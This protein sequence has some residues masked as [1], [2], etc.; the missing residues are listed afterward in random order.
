M[1]KLRE[2]ILHDPHEPTSTS[3]QL[4]YP[5][6]SLSPEV[7]N[8]S[9][10]DGLGGGL[11]HDKSPN[12]ISQKLVLLQYHECHSVSTEEIRF[13]RSRTHTL[14][15]M[16][17]DLSRAVC[18]VSNSWVS[19][20]KADFQPLV[21]SSL[22][23]VDMPLP[24]RCTIAL[25]VSPLQ[26]LGLRPR[27]HAIEQHFF[28]R[29]HMVRQSGRH[30]WRARPPQLGRATTSGGF[31]KPQR[32]TQTGVR[33][34]EIV[35][36]VVHCQLLAQAVLTC[37]QGVDPTPYRCYSLANIQVQPLDKRRVN[38]PA[39]HRQD[40]LNPLHSAKHHPILDPHDASASVGLDHLGIKHL[41]QGHPAWFGQRAFVS[42]ACR[43][44][45]L[46]K[47]GQEGCAVVLETI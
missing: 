32:L 43:L 25:L 40:L 42:T 41:R 26:R 15:I 20:L 47:M 2:G 28:E 11:A 44:P 18:V 34:A 35:V 31:G 6:S 21:E 12:R 23:L 4:P 46:A 36:R 7:N 24:L 5:P 39:T 1:P 30:R 38:L 27:G 45:P 33:Q 13:S 10:R 3:T 19:G 17:R 16:F 22:P 14:R 29:P 9:T 8:H 37:A